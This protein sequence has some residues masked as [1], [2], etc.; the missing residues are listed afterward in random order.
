MDKM[1]KKFDSICV[2]DSSK[3]A[4]FSHTP[5]IFASSTFIYES[6]EKAI[7]V[8][9]GNEKAFIYG[10]WSHPN[11]ELVE[12]KLE[13]LE[14]IDYPDLKV[15]GFL[16]STGM[17][18]IAALFHTVLKPGDTIIAQ[19]SIYGSTVELLNALIKPLGIEVLFIDFDD[20][21]AVESSIKASKN[22][23][24]L[25]AETP[26]NPTLSCCDL[27][28]LSDLAHRYGAQMSV[29]NTFATPY[30]QRPFNFGVDFIVHS[31]TKFLNGHG[32]ALGGFLIGKDVAFMTSA[33]WLQRK[34][35]GAMLSPFDAW[36]LNNGLK[37]LSL[38]MD[39]HCSNAMQVANFLEQHVAVSKCNYLGL[40]S[41]A[42]HELSKQQMTGFGGVLS[43]VLKDGMEAGIRL[44]KNVQFCTLTASLGTA[45]TL[46]QHPASM[47]HSNMPKAQRE[48]SGISD[49][50]IRLSVGI[51]NV[52][53]IIDDLAQ[54]FHSV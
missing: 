40:R 46:I 2:K 15:K 14:S 16:F 18:A 44:M 43:F 42:Y 3:Y 19:A 11:V 51:E 28:A 7:E 17:A 37:T 5:P 34:L 41:S 47:T 48:A 26:S 50:M 8:F 49:G 38:R 32:N 31:T 45:D 36:L 4:P 10:R 29:D 21:A 30:L 24:L 20:I 54:A 35:N 53:D 23:R 1:R 25:Y 22:V 27:R 12:E 9:K 13:A 39:K 6:P 33:V 52:E